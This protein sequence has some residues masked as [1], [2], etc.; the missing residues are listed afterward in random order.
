MSSWNLLGSGKNCSTPV[1][2]TSGRQVEVE[3]FTSKAGVSSS[4]ELGGTEVES[5]MLMAEPKDGTTA[6]DDITTS[7]TLGVVVG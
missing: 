1:L 6:L 5:Y 7:S 4:D 3:E 2:L